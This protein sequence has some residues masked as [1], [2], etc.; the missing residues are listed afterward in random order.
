MYDTFD[1]GIKKGK[2]LLSCQYCHLRFEKTVPN[3]FATATP[4]DL[5]NKLA[6]SQDIIKCPN[7]CPSSIGHIRLYVKPSRLMKD[8][9]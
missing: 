1:T 9:E 7:G 3:E 5:D 6:T 4:K 2:A 8:W